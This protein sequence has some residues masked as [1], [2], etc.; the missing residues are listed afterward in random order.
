MKRTVVVAAAALLLGAGA[1]MA[2]DNL[3]KQSQDIMK[4]N[5]KNLGGVLIAMVKGEKP[6]DQAAVNAA[7]AQLDETA[8]KLPTMYPASMKGAKFEGDYSASPKIWEDQAGFK[9]K[10]E[11]FAK[12][13][14]EAKAKIKDL[15]S[16]KATAPAIGKECGGCHE[17]FR[18][19]NG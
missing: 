9:A 15:D 13:V 5:A 16:L 10:I 3:V 1:V 17:T 6:Y 19:K 12:V 18:L 2:Q 4:A 11:S 14:T 7:L 8:K